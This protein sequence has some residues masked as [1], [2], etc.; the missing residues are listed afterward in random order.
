MRYRLVAI[1]LAALAGTGDTQERRIELDLLAINAEVSEF[2]GWTT[3]SGSVR[4]SGERTIHY[5]QMIM[6]FKLDQKVVEI[7]EIYIEGPAG[8]ELA[9]GETGFFDTLVT[10]TKHDY[11]E[12][13]ITY[14]GRLDAIAPFLVTGDLR[15][16]QETV[17]VV[18]F[19]GNAAVLGEIVNETNAVLTNVVIWFLM[20]DSGGE[21]TGIAEAAYSLPAEIYPDEVIPFRATSHAPLDRV[22]STEARWEFTADRIIHNVATGVE[23]M[24]WAK[25]KIRSR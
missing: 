9:P 7:D 6:A 25:L 20:Y 19:L 21:L 14:D 23:A 4:N 22:V 24:S 2:L 16:L 3:F 5:P 12:Y 11:D 18:E 17:N 10:I 8:H 15:I 1:M 13:M